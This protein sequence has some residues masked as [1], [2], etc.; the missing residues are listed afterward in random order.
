[1]RIRHVVRKK[2]R[3]RPSSLWM[4]HLFCSRYRF[5]EAR[6]IFRLCYAIKMSQ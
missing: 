6:S 3:R 1:M 2:R 4:D 5:F